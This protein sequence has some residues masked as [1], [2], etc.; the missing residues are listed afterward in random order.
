MEVLTRLVDALK[1][2][3]LR[4]LTTVM[5]TMKQPLQALAPGIRHPVQRC[6]CR[7]EEGGEY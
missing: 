1:D 5:D 7:C 2:D 3:G 6:A 4:A